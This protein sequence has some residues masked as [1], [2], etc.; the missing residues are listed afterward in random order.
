M[1]KLVLTLFL[2]TIITSCNKEVS[3]ASD[4]MQ[5][6][7]IRFGTYHN[8]LKGVSIFWRNNS[9]NDSIKWGYSPTFEKG[10]FAA[11]YTRTYTNNQFEYTFPVLIARDTIYY[12]L[13]DS[14]NKSWTDVKKLLTSTDTSSNIFS[15]TFMGD[16]RTNFSDWQSVAESVEK[17]DFTLF[18]GDIMD[19]GKKGKYWDL[20]FDYGKSF[21]ENNLVFHTLG[22]HDIGMWYEKLFPRPNTEVYYSF[23]QGNALFICL[24]SC[25]ASNS[26]QDAFL[27]EQLSLHS[28]K[29][30]KI[31][32]FHHP[33]FSY[34]NHLI[35]SNIYTWW[36]TFDD[37]GVD[38]VLCG[39]THNYQRTKPMILQ[40]NV[41]SIATRYGSELGQGRC[42]IVAGG[43]GGPLNPPLYQWFTNNSFSFY[44]YGKIEINENKLHIT[45]K[46]V[47]GILRDSLTLQ[48]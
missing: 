35:S 34:S 39:H 45:V 42:Q 38:L 31:V 27:K 14:Q 37:Y 5:I 9:I 48:K 19:D 2:F 7:C 28:D 30:W 21:T 46:S 4:A 15:F 6:K 1:K 10:S 20:W 12:T 22:N 32:Y 26:Q 33:F 18:L 36:K 24:N 29:M 40:N 13:F 41:A 23:V 44:H 17:T 3:D 8:T 11:E 43:A 47:D 25:D 16:S